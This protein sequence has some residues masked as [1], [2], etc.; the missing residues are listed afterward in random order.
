M[1]VSNMDVRHVMQFVP[2]PIKCSVSGRMPSSKVMQAGGN[3]INLRC[4]YMGCCS[5]TSEHEL[6]RRL[7]TVV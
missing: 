6:E 1:F 3:I 4:N 2:L 5:H 7:R